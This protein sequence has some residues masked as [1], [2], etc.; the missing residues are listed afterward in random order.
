MAWPKSPQVI[1]EGTRAACGHLK[2]VYTGGRFKIDAMMRLQQA[3]GEL[4]L[5]M[6]TDAYKVLVKTPNSQGE[7]APNREIAADES[8]P[9]PRALAK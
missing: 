1:T 6:I 7:F 3:I 4:G 5:E 9:R 2:V 8:L